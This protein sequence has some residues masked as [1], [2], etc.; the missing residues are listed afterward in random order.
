V[1]YNNEKYGSTKWEGVGEETTRY[2]RAEDAWIKHK[3]IQ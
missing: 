2:K 1:K 3:E